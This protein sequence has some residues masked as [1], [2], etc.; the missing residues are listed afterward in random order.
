[1]AISE[2]VYVQTLTLVLQTDYV[3]DLKSISLTQYVDVV[4]STRPA[5]IPCES[6]KTQ[7]D[8]PKIFNNLSPRNL[9]AHLKISEI[10]IYQLQLGFFTKIK[11]HNR[12]KL[13]NNEED[14]NNHI[15]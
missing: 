8:E 14:N 9:L 3:Q 15:T 2:S 5:L 10:V 6:T 13:R 11:S 12:N 7:Q 1:M 4:T